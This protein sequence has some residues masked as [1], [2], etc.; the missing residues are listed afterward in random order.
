MPNLGELASR[1]VGLLTGLLFV[2][3]P[4]GILLGGLCWIYGVTREWPVGAPGVP[5]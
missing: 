4:E 1:L 2:T 3:R 5:S